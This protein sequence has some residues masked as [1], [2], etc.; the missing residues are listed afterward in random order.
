MPEEIQEYTVTNRTIDLIVLN[1]QFEKIAVID[2]YESLLWTDRYNKPGDFEIYTPVAKSVLQYPVA[3]NYLQIRDSEHVMIIEDT[4]IESNIETGNHIKIVGRSLESILDRRIVWAQTDITGN[5]QNG[6]QKLLNENV[7]SPSIADR[8][9]SNFIFEAST[10]PAITELEVESQYT[11]DNLLEVI[12]TLCESNKIG[13]KIT[14]NDNNQFVFKLYKG[15]DRSYSQNT[16]SY[17]V[18]KPSFENIINSNYS[19]IQSGAKTLALIAG[20]GEGA[21]RVTRT[22]GT[23]VG[24][25]RKELYV[26]ARDIQSEEIS[27]EQ[28]YAKLDQRGTEK[29]NEN[30]VQKTFDGQCETTRMFRYQEAFFMGDIV[31]VAD[32]YGMESA[33][34]VTE[35]IWSSNQ[36]G[37]ESYPTFEAL[38]NDE[39]NNEEEN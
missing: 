20:E 33:A 15:T 13:F 2:T 9:I 12:K 6:I 8:A 37:I 3:N 11:G 32:E 21:Q 29:L 22:V 39:L 19:D 4:T 18:F 31:Q 14:L 16:N 34:R 28:Y 35:F 17:V 30:K 38:N 5:L 24:L 27:T 10:D 36:S 25:D 23:G 26:D 7:I 1:Q